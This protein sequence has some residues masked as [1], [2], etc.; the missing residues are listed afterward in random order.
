MADSPS[1][2]RKGIG[3]LTLSRSSLIAVSSDLSG[4]SAGYVDRP[5]QIGDEELVYRRVR[6]K[7]VDWT[8]LDGGGNP[9]I[10]KNVFSDAPWEE[11]QRLGCP[12]RAMSVSV[13]SILIAYNLDP[14]EYL[15][16]GWPDYGLAQMR[17]GDLRAQGDQGVQLWPTADDVSHAV[18]FTL[19]AGA[20]KRKPGQEDRTRNAAV[21]VVL[22]SGLV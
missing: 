15:L 10:N 19:R 3:D 18:V 12:G 4:N 8:K 21:W 6:P 20:S 9:K 16:Q 17:V 5:G 22:P 14:K 7:G 13:H 2:Y 1:S 11:A